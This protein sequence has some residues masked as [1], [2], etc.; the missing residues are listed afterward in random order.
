[1]ILV[2]EAI[3][4]YYK[5][6]ALEQI[7]KMLINRYGFENLPG[8]VGLGYGYYN[9]ELFFVGM[10]PGQA[11]NRRENGARCMSDYDLKQKETGGFIL[12]S[13]LEKYYPKNY[14]NTNLVKIPTPSN[15]EPSTNL[16]KIFMPYLKLELAI[17]RPKLIIALGSWVYN[18]LKE[19]MISTVKIYHPAY[20]A[21]DKE[22]RLLNYTESIRE[23]K[24][25]LK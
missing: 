25:R 10:N 8:N 17:I 24:E 9:S 3:K 7:E 19:Y 20:I 15:K 11:I 13:L 22:N 1:M 18:T 23:L 12:L 4:L 21:R 16:V 6:V 14:Y 5:K 2:N